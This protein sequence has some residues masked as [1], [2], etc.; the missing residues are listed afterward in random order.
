MNPLEMAHKNGS[1]GVNGHPQP[2]PPQLDE[3]RLGYDRARFLAQPPPPPP[4]AAVPPRRATTRQRPGM[5]PYSRK[6]TGDIYPSRFLSLDAQLGRVHQAGAGEQVYGVSQAE[7]R[8]WPPPNPTNV[9]PD[10]PRA[11][12]AGE[13]VFIYGP[14]AA[15]VPLCYGANVRIGD[16]LKS[17]VN[18]MAVKAGPL[19]EVGAVAQEEGG[20]GYVGLVTIIPP[21]K[22]HSPV[23]AAAGQ[24]LPI[25]DPEEVSFAAMI[26]RTPR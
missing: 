12:A 20:P 8:N 24:M 7:N 1:N 14:P 21:H 22:L 19:D 9:L 3:D 26:R 11:A 16:R 10:D 15:D 23:L 2:A 25:P 6:A 17:D 5:P 18:G 13:D 4:V